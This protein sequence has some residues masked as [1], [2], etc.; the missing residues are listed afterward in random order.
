MLS[1]LI[2]L[3]GCGKKEAPLK[4]DPGIRYFKQ[5]VP[6]DPPWDGTA[7]RKDVYDKLVETDG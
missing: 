3:P 5:G 7:L 1:L 6:F 4:T 2:S